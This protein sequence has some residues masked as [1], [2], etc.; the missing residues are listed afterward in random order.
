[1]DQP[2]KIK[3]VGT[4]Y[5]GGQCHGFMPGLV[6]DVPAEH[7]AHLIKAGHAKVSVPEGIEATGDGPAV[8]AAA[9]A[10]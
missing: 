7:A 2:V 9:S 8:N 3:T 4:I 6:I 5:F 1:M 10:P